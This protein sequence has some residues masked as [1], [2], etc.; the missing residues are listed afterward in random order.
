MIILPFQ[1]I[2]NYVLVHSERVSF[3]SS[4]FLMQKK[5]INIMYVCL[6]L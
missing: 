1:S 3:F 6:L 2:V 5:N 4:F